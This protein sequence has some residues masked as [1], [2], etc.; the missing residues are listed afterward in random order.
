[1]HL[2]ADRNLLNNQGSYKYQGVW[3]Q[4]DQMMVSRPMASYL[5]DG[6]PRIF[7]DKFMLTNDKT[8]RGE[9]LQRIYYGYKYEGGFSDHLPV[10]ADFIIPI[11]E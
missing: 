1:V 8:W 2:F 6:S 10:V 7:N 3:N 9:R 11:I 5:K 4:L